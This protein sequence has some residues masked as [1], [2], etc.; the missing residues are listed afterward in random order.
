[1]REL[2]GTDLVDPNRLTFHFPLYLWAQSALAEFAQPNLAA[3]DLTLHRS[4][5]GGEVLVI[6]GREDSVFSP[7]IGRTIA[8]AYPQ[9]YFLSVSGGHRLEQNRPYQHALRAAFIRQGLSATETRYLL[10]TAP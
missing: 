2:T 6:A 4:R 1:M 3:P 9:G 7:A 10:S 8:Q 5:F